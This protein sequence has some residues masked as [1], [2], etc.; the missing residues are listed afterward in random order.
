MLSPSEGKKLLIL[1]AWVKRTI[2]K[3]NLINFLRHLG[4]KVF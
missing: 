4:V 1:N 3:I 2:E